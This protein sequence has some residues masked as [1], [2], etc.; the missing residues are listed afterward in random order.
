LFNHLF[1]FSFRLFLL[2]I[3]LLSR[4]APAWGKRGS[5]P[6]ENPVFAPAAVFNNPLFPLILRAGRKNMTPPF[7]VAAQ[8]QTSYLTLSF[9]ATSCGSA[10]GEKKVPSVTSPQGFFFR[11][12]FLDMAPRQGRRL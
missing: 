3:F 8:G 5:A 12:G 2:L 1:S 10:L 4:S 9:L 11:R 6:F 7:S